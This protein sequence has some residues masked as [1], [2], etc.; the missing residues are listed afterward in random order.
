M[1]DR[2]AAE[3]L[4]VKYRMTGAQLTAIA[5]GAFLG[6]LLGAFLA[7]LMFEG[8]DRGSL[9]MSALALA[10][11]FA[12]GIRSRTVTATDEQVSVQGFAGR[13]FAWSDVAE[14]QQSR[15]LGVSRLMIVENSG[16]RT[17]LPVPVDGRL[18]MRDRRFQDKAQTLRAALD[19]SRQVQS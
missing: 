17:R 15:S 6:G 8:F 1:I 7:A 9:L 2:E 16:L 19:R 14:I 12:I 18:L 10:A 3:G 4:A 11:G 13:A 5:S